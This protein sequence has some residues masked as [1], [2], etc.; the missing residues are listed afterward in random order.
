MVI[1]RHSG[2]VVCSGIALYIS[3]AAGQGVT[4]EV[5]ELGRVY[6]SGGVQAERTDQHAGQV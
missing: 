6:G 1:N 3:A 4:G 2:I 5:C